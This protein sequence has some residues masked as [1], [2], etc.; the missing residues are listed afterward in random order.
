MPLFLRAI[1]LS[2]RTFWRYLL[3]LPVLA[4]ASLLAVL[5]AAFI[6]VTNLV[7]PG[8][9]GVFCTLAGMRC[10]LVAR[11]H[12]TPVDL[13][14]LE[15][16]SLVF[17]VMNIVAIT[18]IGLVLSLSLAL[19]MRLHPVGD[20][21]RAG[22]PADAE[23]L[24][25][26]AGAFLLNAVLFGLYGSAIAVP[27]TEAAA[28]ATRRGVG[29]GLFFGLGRGMVSLFLITLV[30]FYGGRFF[31]LFGEVWSLLLMIVSTLL[32]VTYGEDIPWD[33]DISLGSLLGGTLF[34]TWASSWYFAT[35]VL[36]WEEAGARAAKAKTAASVAAR[37]SG[38]DLR[39]L[40][41]SRQKRQ[42]AAAG[43]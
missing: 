7:V 8:A 22:T 31:A 9:V 42:E 6:P 25:V 28:S 2:F 13:R 43:D 3:L 26:G 30:W 23:V 37:P 12:H 11:G 39:A 18:A 40:R 24:A 20:G 5:I 21:F 16:A 19:L 4:V 38:D 1:P 36:A 17:A 41:Q 27:M 14:Q 15:W 35:A 34:M 10:A 33:W 32:A 29:R